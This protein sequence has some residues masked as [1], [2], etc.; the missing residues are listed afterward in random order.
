MAAASRETVINIRAQGRQRDLIDR[1]A[2]VVGRNRSEFMLD[3]ACRAA[4]D[5]LLDQA[6]IQIGPE[7]RE[8]LEAMLD[9]PPDENPGLRA[10]LARRPAW[11]R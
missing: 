7:A 1:A 4:E 6:V 8:R 3:A 9:A 11:E 2:E 10:L 5:A